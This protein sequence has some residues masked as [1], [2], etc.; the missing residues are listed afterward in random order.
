ME[1]QAHNYLQGVSWRREEMRYH[2][3]SHIRKRRKIKLWERSYGCRK[4]PEVGTGWLGHGHE[5]L[6]PTRGDILP[7]QH[8]P[9]QEQNPGR[10]LSG[11]RK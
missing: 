5:S 8:L 3:V 6:S 7:W 11:P 1:M 4:L 2:Y 10:K 9:V